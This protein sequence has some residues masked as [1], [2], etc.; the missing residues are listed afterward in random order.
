MRHVVIGISG[1]S[2]LG[3]FVNSYSPDSVWMIAVFFVILSASVFFI[4]LL[5]LKKIRRAALLTFGVI[6]WLILRF[7]G[8]REL[9]YPIL[10]IPILISLEI[11]FQN[12]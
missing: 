6:L 3:W 7:L 8:L 4:S 2:L 9:Y 10:L 5:F 1:I 12:R 11:L